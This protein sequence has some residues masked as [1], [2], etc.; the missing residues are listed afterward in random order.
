MNQTTSYI[1]ELQGIFLTLHVLER[2]GMTP[3][4]AA[5]QVYMGEVSQTPMRH[6]VLSSAIRG[7]AQVPQGQEA[8][9]AWAVFSAC[10]KAAEQ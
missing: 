7:A 1:L 5:T 9:F 2:D 8:H 3:G 4:Q 10:L 6:D